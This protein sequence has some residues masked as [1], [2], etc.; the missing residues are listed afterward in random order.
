MPRKK[1]VAVEVKQKACILQI[2][3]NQK[4]L[5]FSALFSEYNLCK[6]DL[7]GIGEKLLTKR[8]EA[9][10]EVG[11]VEKSRRIYRLTDTG[12]AVVT[13]ILFISDGIAREEKRIKLRKASKRRK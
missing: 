12:Q 2:L 1:R 13:F 7:S 4:R 10:V 5:T 9:L 8:I 6:I 3:Y 11:W